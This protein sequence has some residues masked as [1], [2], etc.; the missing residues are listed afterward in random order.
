MMRVIANDAVEITRFA[1][2]LRR[3]LK[4][5]KHNGGGF[6]CFL[7]DRHGTVILQIEVAL[8]ITSLVK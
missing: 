3:A 8:P 4:D 7:H 6:S 1:H 2:D 5:S